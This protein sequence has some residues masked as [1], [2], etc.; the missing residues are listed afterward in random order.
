MII[1]SRGFVQE[2]WQQQNYY[3][4]CQNFSLLQDRFVI[5]SL[6]FLFWFQKHATGSRALYRKSAITPSLERSQY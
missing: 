4:Y 5:Q 1:E 3:N 6:R 2:R